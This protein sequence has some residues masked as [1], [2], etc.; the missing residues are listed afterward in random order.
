M[1]PGAAKIVIPVTHPPPNYMPSSSICIQSSWQYSKIPPTFSKDLP[2]A[3]RSA[4]D[5]GYSTDH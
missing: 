3:I 5:W 2:E 1:H 4:I